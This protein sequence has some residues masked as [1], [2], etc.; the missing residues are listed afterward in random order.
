LL[1][2]LDAC[3]NHEQEQSCRALATLAATVHA[4][5]LDPLAL[6]PALRTRAGHG[7]EPL[8]EP[9]LP[10]SL[11]HLA[12]DASAPRLDAAAPT[13][14]AAFEPRDLDL[15]VDSRGRLFQRDLQLVLE[16]FAAHG[17]RAATAAAAAAREEVL[18]DVL[19]EC[20]EPRVAEASAPADRPEAVVLRALVGIGEHRVR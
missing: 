18:E 2:V 14:L 19:E 15:G 3:W 20:P 9:D 17:P 4:R 13:G 5:G 10:A 12:H 7:Q 11:A 16:I 1:A 6:S 8:R